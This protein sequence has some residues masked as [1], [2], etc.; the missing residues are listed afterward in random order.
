MQTDLPLKDKVIIV[1][2]GTGVLGEAFVKALAR[3][4]AAV[5]IL[6]RNEQVAEERA[7]LVNNQGG[8]AMTLLADV[9]DE[10]Q[11]IAA[12]EK[13][14][15]AWGRIDGL[16]NAAG[17]NIPDAVIQ[18]GQDIFNLNITALEQVMRLNLFGTLLPT[19]VFG[20][21]IRKNGS[22]SIVN[23]SSVTS[24][25]AVTRV[26]GYSLAKA[27]IESYTKWF[28]VELAKRYGD[29]IRMNTLIPGFFLTSQNKTL[30][31]QPDG[32]LT[33]RGEL[34]INKT[35][36]NRFGNPDELTGALVFLLSDASRFVTGTGITVDG[37]FSVFSGV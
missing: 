14:I 20:D 1:T 11:L 18:P 5:G 23:I 36:F 26:L 30:L 21:A 22:G 17:G 12:R 16:V 29:R 25:L 8:K 34:I 37:G 3:A 19:Q 13:I 27:A 35:P 10:Q 32:S 2:G 9:T 24:G 7:A 15:A 6:G 31:T 4:G 33:N 28:A